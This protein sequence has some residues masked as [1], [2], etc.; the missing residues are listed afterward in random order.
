MEIRCEND[1]CE[2]RDGISCGSTQGVIINIDRVCETFREKLISF[3][4]QQ[5]YDINDTISNA[6][7][8]VGAYNSDER[9]AVARIA[10][11]RAIQE[12]RRVG[13]TEIENE[14]GDN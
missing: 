9:E 1:S 3:T 5:I 6:I 13:I 11:E 10:I 8:Y 2:F 7:D 14:R 4:T 12:K